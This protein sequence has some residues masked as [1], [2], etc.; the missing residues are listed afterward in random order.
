[1]TVRLR[2]VSKSPVFIYWLLWYSPSY[3]EST[4]ASYTKEKGDSIKQYRQNRAAPLSPEAHSLLLLYYWQPSN[5]QC[6]KTGPH[7]V[8]FFSKMRQ[9]EGP[10]FELTPTSVAAWRSSFP[11]SELATAGG[12]HVLLTWWSGWKSSISDTAA[13]KPRSISLL[14]SADWWAM[15]SPA[16]FLHCA[17]ETGG[18][19][20]GNLAFSSSALKQSVFMGFS[21]LTLVSSPLESLRTIIRDGF[22]FCIGT[23]QFSSILAWF[24]FFLRRVRYCFLPLVKLSLFR[25]SKLMH[26][27]SS[28]D[29]LFLQVSSSSSPT[30]KLSSA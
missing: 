7:G 24:N 5:Q 28:L 16:I 3:P 26:T 9:E 27:S 29:S 30:Q 15:I 19:D 18:N 10:C 23:E 8:G 12:K 4:K 20:V 17:E 14:A 2:I 13:F 22:F 21:L 25:R 11:R 1:M 6:N